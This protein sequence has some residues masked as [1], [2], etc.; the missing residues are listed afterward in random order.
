MNRTDAICVLVIILVIVGIVSAL[1][2]SWYKDQDKKGKS[3]DDNSLTV[4]EGDLIT[5]DFTEYIYTKDADGNLGYCVY[6]TTDEEIALDDSIPKCVTFNTILL[7]STG[8]PIVREQMT[9]II[10][11]DLSDEVN[12]GFNDLMLSLNVREDKTYH[13]DISMEDGYGKRNESLEKKIQLMDTVDIYKMIDRVEFEAR[14]PNELPLMLGMTFND[15][16]WNWTIRI[17]SITNETITIK[18][19]PNIGMTLDIFP[20]SVTVE[21]ISSSAGV[22]SIQHRPDMSIINSAIDAEALQFYNKT[23]EDLTAQIIE[24]QQPYPGI[25]ISIQDGITID[26]NRE[27]FGVELRYEFKIIKIERD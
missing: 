16:Y 7:N 19:E 27:N 22:I 11:R 21:S 10:G 26:F 15:I 25:I 13:G 20:W 17:E 6:Q 2:Y 9:A 4:Q 3:K 23:F 12:P 8:D 24:S 18:N 14:Y 5:F 1:A